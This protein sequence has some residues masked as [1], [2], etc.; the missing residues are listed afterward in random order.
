[1]I[2]KNSKKNFAEKSLNVLNVKLLSK[3]FFWHFWLFYAFL[4]RMSACTLHIKQFPWHQEPQQPQWPQQPQQPQ[5]PQ[6][7]QQPHFIK[8]LTELDVS[9]NSGTKL[10]YPGLSMWNESP[11]IPYFIDYWH[12]FCWRL[13]R[14]WMLI[15]I[16]SKDHKSNVP[17]QCMHRQLFYGWKF[18]FRCPSKAFVSRISLWNTLYINVVRQTKFCQIASILVETHGHNAMQAL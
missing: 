13:W 18:N 8:K 10:T 16:K 15:L 17:C 4:V 11:K 14:P 2:C 12:F 5:W 7:S 1:M 6:W 9:F 3:F